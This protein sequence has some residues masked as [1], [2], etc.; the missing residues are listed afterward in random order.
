MSIHPDLVPIFQ[1][2]EEWEQEFDERRKE[3]LEKELKASV[4]DVL[5]ARALETKVNFR[6]FLYCER[7]AYRAWRTRKH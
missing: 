3:E 5:R 7:D 4:L 2:W 6:D 1:K